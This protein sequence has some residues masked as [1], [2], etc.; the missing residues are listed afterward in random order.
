[1]EDGS[2]PTLLFSVALLAGGFATERAL[3]SWR[4]TPWFAAGL[5]LV[6][7]PVPIPEAPTGSG[8]TASLKWEVVDGVVRWW[9]DPRRRGA[10]PTG[11]RG[12][13]RLRRSTRGVELDVRWSPPWTPL[14][15]MGWLAALGVMRGQT[16]VTGPIAALLVLAMLLV[17]HQGALRAAAELRWAF[18][19]DR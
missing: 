7:V 5:P 9:A 18:V 11:L 1:M 14:V 16:Q 4:W 13:V 6:P 8:E 10:V 2:L 3:L 17:Y 12:V 19:R 15:A